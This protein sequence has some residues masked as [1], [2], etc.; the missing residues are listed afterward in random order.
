MGPLRFCS[1]PSL[2]I[3]TSMFTAIVVTLVFLDLAIDRDPV[4]F[5]ATWVLGRRRN[6]SLRRKA[7]PWFAISLLIIALGVVAFWTVDL[8]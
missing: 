1:H 2:G 8:F 4:G 3:L 6:D 7:R 5:S